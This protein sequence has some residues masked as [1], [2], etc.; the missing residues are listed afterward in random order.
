MTRLKERV[1]RYMKDP[2]SMADGR[3]YVKELPPDGSRNGE[4]LAWLH[5]PDIGV[6]GGREM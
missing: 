2:P 4:P 5:E 1:K 3:A 6:R